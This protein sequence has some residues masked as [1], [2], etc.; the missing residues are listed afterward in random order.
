MLKICNDCVRYL[1]DIEKNK[2]DWKFFIEDM[3][4]MWGFTNMFGPRVMLGHKRKQKT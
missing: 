3:D 4:G 2:V 1:L